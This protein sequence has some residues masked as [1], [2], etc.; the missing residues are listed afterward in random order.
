LVGIDGAGSG[1]GAAIAQ[2]AAFVATGREGGSEVCS[3]ECGGGKFGCILLGDIAYDGMDLGAV[4]ICR[5]A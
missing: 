2:G 4:L 5:A 3:F 1:T